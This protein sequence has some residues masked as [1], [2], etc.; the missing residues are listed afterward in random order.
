M[1]VAASGQRGANKF[2]GAL[3]ARQNTCVQV[4]QL[5]TEAQKN[6]CK[7]NRAHDRGKIPCVSQVLDKILGADQIL[8]FSWTLTSIWCLPSKRWSFFGPIGLFC[9]AVLCLL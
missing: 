6:C 3:F 2:C 7:R 9:P 1:K 4:A 5:Q 8:G